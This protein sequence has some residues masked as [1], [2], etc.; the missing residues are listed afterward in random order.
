MALFKK[1]KKEEKTA[2]AQAPAQ[3]RA[4]TAAPRRD[5]QRDISTVLRSPRITEK[6]TF[7]AERNV[8]V[9]EVAPWANKKEVAQAITYTYKVEPIKVNVVQVKPK[10]LRSSFRRRGGTKSGGKK[11]YIYL[12]EGDRI[13]FV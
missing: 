2:Q 5:G 8:Y 9:F 10:Q 12:K 13:E 1:E 3:E 7:A 4:S 6:A 11:A